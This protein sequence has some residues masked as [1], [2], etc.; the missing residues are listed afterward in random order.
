MMAPEP[1]PTPVDLPRVRLEVRTG[2]NRSVGYEVGTSEFLIGSAPACDLRLPLPGL[3]PVAVQLSLKSDGVRVRRSSPNLEVQLNA[4]PLPLNAIATLKNGDHLVIGD[5]EIHV[6]IQL[7]RFLAARL[8]PIA[9]SEAPREVPV[10]ELRQERSLTERE[11]TLDELDAELKDREAGLG[12]REAAITERLTEQEANFKAQVAGFL[13]RERQIEAQAAELSASREMWTRRCSEVQQQLEKQGKELIEG[14][15]KFEAERKGVHEDRTRQDRDATDRFRASR[16]EIERQRQVLIA[17]RHALDRGRETFE[18]QQVA[19]TERLRQWEATLTGRVTELAE[20]EAA[21]R[22]MRTQFDSDRQQYT[23]DLVRLERK[24][25]IIADLERERATREADLQLHSE[26]MTRLATEVQERSLSVAAEEARLRAEAER[27]ERLRAELDARATTLAQQAAEIEGQQSSLTAQRSRLERTRE[28]VSREAAQLAQARVREDEAQEHLRRRI[29]EAEQLRADLDSVQENSSLERQ[30]LTERDSLLSA[31]L[32]ELRRQRE[33]IA[34]EELRLRERTMDF[35]TRLADFSEQAGALKSRLSQAF[36]LQARLEADRVALRER[37]AT[38]IQAE[39]ARQSL[40]DQVRR[41]AEELTSRGKSLDELARVLGGQKAALDQAEAEM[42]GHRA[43]C[44]K[45]V[46]A[47][48]QEIVI[49]SAEVE[50][51]AAAYAEREAGLA[52]QV[53]RLQ[54]VGRAVAAE[55]KALAESRASWMV[56]RAAFLDADRSARTEADAFREKV[57]SEIETLRA[58]VPELDEHARSALDRLH[59]ARDMFRGH[60][61]ELHDYAKQTREDLEGVRKS[62]REEADRLRTQ[63]QDLDRARAEHRH[64]IT[65]FRQQL[66]EWKGRIAEIRHTLSS[67]ESRLEAK[68]AAVSAAAKQIDSNSLQLAQQSEQLRRDRE[69]VAWKR[70][71]VERHLSDMREWYR[72][73]LRDLANSELATRSP[74]DAPE[75]TRPRL[76]EVSEEDP[77]PVDFGEL[78]PGDLQLGELLLSAE[79]V[80]AGSLTELWAEAKRQR[81]TLR[82]VLL[83]SGVITLYQLALIEAGNLDGLVLGR[84]RV[85]DRIRTSPRE[86]V[87]RVFDPTRVDGPTDGLYLL[88]H[89]TEAEGQDAVHP[90]EFRQRFA[91][92]RDA[93]HPNLAGVVEVL[94]IQTRPAV[95]LD[96]TTGL[97]GSEFPPYSSNAGCWLRLMTMAADGLSAAHR[98]GLVHGALTSESLILTAEGTLKLTGAADPPWLNGAESSPETSMAADLR[99]LGQIA[100]V[101]SQT[102]VRKRG[103]KPFPESLARV[104]RRLNSD[105]AS[106]MEDTMAGDRPFASAA[107]LAT[108]LHQLADDISFSEE[109]WEKFLRHVEENTPDRPSMLRR[110]A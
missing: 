7:G 23:E 105:D 101:W 57:T 37:E 109:A 71:S 17:D 41:R 100:F 59:T 2:T 64:S 77:L 1:P 103:T 21:V 69:A 91:A 95:L 65:T 93:A 82:Q 63:E 6:A 54:D 88:R 110:S 14:W 43:E 74:D 50:R 42:A 55:R 106:P 62:L 29:R 28:D 34:Q 94:E 46:S 70:T 56:E 25:A 36:D 104:V 76:A 83:A 60:L 33:A 5:V 79:L 13:D 73:K 24:Q 27:A 96:A 26:Q 3:P 9:S 45:E 4:S 81:R 86:N 39:E 48:R 35:E 52:R 85:I 61:N 68:E 38:L 8:V 72:S 22:G 51:Q 32:E 89:L 30:R 66:I 98:V 58:Q 10:E 19:E 44:A 87:Y 97:A 90:D 18:A 49:R 75:L 11:A 92:A 80:E 47:K 15:A 108:H 84:F 20:R 53:A 78:D 40:Q 99:A 31:G 16:E 107:E 102:T 12:Q 67:S